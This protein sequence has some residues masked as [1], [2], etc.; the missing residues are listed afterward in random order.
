MI[1]LVVLM[2]PMAQGTDDAPFR[3]LPRSSLVRVEAQI[4]V[5][6]FG[7]TLRPVGSFN[8]LCI[9]DPRTMI[10]PSYLARATVLLSAKGRVWHVRYTVRTQG[11]PVMAHVLY[12]DEDILLLRAGGDIGEPVSPETFVLP[13]ED[14]DRAILVRTESEGPRAIYVTWEPR[15]TARV[16]RQRWI[17]ACSLYPDWLGAVA[18][19]EAALPLG[20]LVDFRIANQNDSVFVLHLNGVPPSITPDA[21]VIM[22]ASLDLPT[23]LAH[24]ALFALSRLDWLGLQGK[25][26]DDVN[27]VV[28]TA[29]RALGLAAQA[30]IASRDRIVAL[31]GHKAECDS[32]GRWI[33][34]GADV[35]A[36]HRQI[37]IL[38]AGREMEFRIDGGGPEVDSPMEPTDTG[39]TVR[40]CYPPGQASTLQVLDVAPT[41]RSPYNLL[42]SGDVLLTIDGQSVAAMQATLPPT[43]AGTSVEVLRDGRRIMWKGDS[44]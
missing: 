15:P 44:R 21:R 23:L 11:D 14:A 6:A 29:V 27:G 20:M 16:A 10:C 25:W 7:R 1:P 37:S 18:T 35:S 30:G 2:A 22:L 39:L 19:N 38:R 42:Q 12:Q 9:G 34:R 26:D 13:A 40:R 8:G 41:A 43:A 28:V 24:H 3:G 36:P 31:D 17:P 5:T 33:F 4:V 32:S